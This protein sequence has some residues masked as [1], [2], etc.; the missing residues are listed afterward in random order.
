MA[1]SKGDFA[2]RLRMCRAKANLTQAELA[3]LIDA[4]EQSVRN[5][6]KDLYMP[7]LR[8]TV[9]LAD[10]LNVSLDQLTGREPM[11]VA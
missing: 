11:V 10:V 3:N 8:T 1:N 9:R 4:D 6:E 2:T 5:W 7:S